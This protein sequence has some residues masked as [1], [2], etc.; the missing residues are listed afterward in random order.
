MDRIIGAAALDRRALIPHLSSFACAIPGYARYRR[1]ALSVEDHSG[2]SA[3]DVLGA[4]L[5]RH[6]DYLDF[7]P[8][9]LL[10]AV[11]QPAG[12]GDVRALFRREC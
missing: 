4:H 5:Y 3:H 9:E 1:S 12:L 11:D 10:D 2:R 7:H 6:A 8:V